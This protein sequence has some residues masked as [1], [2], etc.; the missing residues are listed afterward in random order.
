W[1]RL[2]NRFGA[3][4]KGSGAAHRILSSTRTII[5]GGGI[6]GL[7]AAYYLSKAG[8]PSTIIERRPRLGGVIE[9]ERIDD[10]VLEGGPASYLS[11]KPAATELIREMGLDD[12]IIGSNDHLRVTYVLR[13]GRLVPLPDGLMMIAPTKIAPLVRTN[14][15]G[16]P[17]KIRM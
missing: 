13:R 8:V 14:L 5:I 11:V 4:T 1:S 9:T 2:S 7:S 15:L 10:C 17:T 6:S 12:Q 16:W 3:T